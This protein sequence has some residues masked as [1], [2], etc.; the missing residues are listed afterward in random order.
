MY[1]DL[2]LCVLDEWGGDE[3]SKRGEAVAV[4]HFL[5][6]KVKLRLSQFSAHREASNS[7]YVET[8]SPHR[9]DDGKFI[10]LIQSQFYHNRNQC[11]IVIDYTTIIN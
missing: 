1:T 4:P 3:T 11:Y 8:C 6:V 9:H 2:E 10:F 5:A 7:L